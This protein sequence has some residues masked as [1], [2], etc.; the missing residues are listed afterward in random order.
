[1]NRQQRWSKISDILKEKQSISTEELIRLLNVSPAT[2]R[3]DLQDMEDLKI[4]SRFHG[5]VKINAKQYDEPHMIIKSETNTKEKKAIAITAASLIKDHQMIY[6]DAGSTTL[7]IIQYIHAKNITVVTPGIRH[8]LE[9]AKK[10]INTIVLG[11]PLNPA[12]E[13]VAGRNTVEQIRSMY[14]DIAFIGTN[15]IH[16]KIGFTTSSETEAATKSAAIKQSKAPYIV[17]DSSKFFLLNPVRFAEISDAVI[18]SDSI[19]EE[20][21]KLPLKYILSSGENNL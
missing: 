18:I 21:K 17:T 9:L 20:F 15:G 5:G 10:D 4:I 16:E 6:L 1:M 12:T 11:G 3:R 7:E 14:F 2:V 19:P 13:A 8:I